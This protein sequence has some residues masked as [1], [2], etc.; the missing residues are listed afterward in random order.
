WKRYSIKIPD[1]TQEEFDREYGQWHVAYH[2]TKSI[3]AKNILLTGL[4][5]STSGV[6]NKERACVYLSPSIE[7]CAH[8]LYA[9]PWSKV[10]NDRKTYIQMIFQCRVKPSAIEI[11]GETVLKSKSIR[12][13]KNFR[14]EVIEWVIPVTDSQDKCIN[15]IIVCYGIMLRK[16]NFDPDQLPQSQWWK[17]SH[18]GLKQCLE[19]Y[20][21]E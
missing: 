20:K 1:K 3:N 16:C 21:H 8:P 19:N 5:A 17:Y 15:N 9:E 6:Y 7:Y 13:D 14:N 18:D 11:H 4:L 10:E 12:I 2:G